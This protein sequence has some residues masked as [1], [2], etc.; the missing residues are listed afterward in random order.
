MKKNLISI[1]FSILLISIQ[2]KA[3]NY[4]NPIMDR[5]CPD[6][7]IHFDQP[8]ARYHLS[9]SKLPLFYSSD[10]INWSQYSGKHRLAR[11]GSYPSWADFKKDWAPEI[12]KIGNNFVAYLTLNDSTNNGKDTGIIGVAKGTTLTKALDV[13]ATHVIK[14]DRFGVI[15]PSYFLDPKDNKQYLLFKLDT[16]KYP[17]E[18]K[19]SRILIRELRA[20]GLKFATGSKTKTLL[21]GGYT[22]ETKYEGQDMVEHDGYYYL[23]YTIGTFSETYHVRVARSTSP[24]GP[25]DKNTSRMFLEAEPHTPLGFFYAPGHGKT[26]M[27]GDGL[28][29]LYHSK[30]RTVSG[31]ANQYTRYPM[32]DKIEFR[33]GWPILNPGQNEG[34]PS[35]GS[36]PI[37]TP[38]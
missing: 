6:P 23:F 12:V 18:Q 1:I 32:L 13:E 11:K 20:D 4:T 3:A 17:N 14:N 25:F 34:H 36:K 19:P 31:A 37:P 26:I 29:Y 21:L 35:R 10:M 22:N 15:D 8:T 7:A 5:N 24:L 27:T 9:C 38:L 2:T 28:Y 33:D 16:N 30:I